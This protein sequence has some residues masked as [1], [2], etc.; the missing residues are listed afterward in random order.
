MAVRSDT[1][2]WRRAAHLQA[3]TGLRVDRRMGRRWQGRVD[4][5]QLPK[6]LISTGG[7][8]NPRPVDAAQ[9]LPRGCPIR[10]ETISNGPPQ[11]PAAATSSPRSSS[12]R[13]PAIRCRAAA[14]T[15]RPARRVRRA[16]MLD[17]ARTPTRGVHD[18]HR[19]R[20]GSSLHRPDIGHHGTLRAQ[21][22]RTSPTPDTQT[23]RSATRPAA[24]RPNVAQV[25]S[26]A[27][28]SATACP[29]PPGVL[30][31]ALADRLSNRRG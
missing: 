6:H 20:P 21:L 3:L 25:G 19:P 29:R 14:L 30:G 11:V 24:Q 4:Q 5:H 27:P 12:A 13:P 16:Q 31:E 22:V 9:R 23:R 15:P 8:A 10:E 1:A 2:L 18:L 28:R 7:L 17:V 26:P